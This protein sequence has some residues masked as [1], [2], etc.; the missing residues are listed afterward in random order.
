[1]AGTTL[2]TRRKRTK[3]WPR[4]LHEARDGQR[5]CPLP[6]WL[7]FGV[8]CGP[9]RQA[10]LKKPSGLLMPLRRRF[11]TGLHEKPTQ[12]RPSGAET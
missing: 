3:R 7:G 10:I 6:P 8:G 2:L 1:M 4:D 11:L 5:R 12:V 9:A